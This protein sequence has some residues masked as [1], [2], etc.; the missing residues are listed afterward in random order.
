M[1]L[2]SCAFNV[3]SGG[4]EEDRTP[5]LCIA[6]AIYAYPRIVAFL[7]LNTGHPHYDTVFIDLYLDYA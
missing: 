3:L 4:G 6:N 2:K 1:F 7:P 5:D